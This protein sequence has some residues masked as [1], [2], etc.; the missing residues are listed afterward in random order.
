MCCVALY[1]APYNYRQDFSVYLDS[2]LLPS[3]DLQ[4]VL[5]EENTSKPVKKYV[6][7]SSREIS[8]HLLTEHFM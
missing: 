3:F 4:A 8:F 6:K 5:A 7:F 2:T 1:H